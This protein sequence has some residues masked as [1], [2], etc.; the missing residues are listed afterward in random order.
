MWLPLFLRVLSAFTFRNF[1][2]PQ[3]LTHTLIFYIL[4]VLLCT[5]SPSLRL[6]H[7]THVLTK[8]FSIVEVST[9]VATAVDESLSKQHKALFLR[10]QLAAINAELQRLEPGNT[11]LHGTGGVAED[12]DDLDA[13]GRRVDALPAGTEVRRVASTEARRLR[14]IPP[15]NAEHGV[16]RNYVRNSTF[17]PHPRF[18]SNTTLCCFCQ[19]EWLTAL[20]WTLPPPGSDTLMRS[21]FLANAKLQLDADHF[22]LD[23]VKRRLTEYLAVVR[24]RALITQEAEM[25]QAKAHEVELKD[26]IEDQKDKYKDGTSKALVRA[27]DIPSPQILIPSSVSTEA[28]KVTK[29]IKAP[30]L[31]CVSHST[32][33]QMLSWT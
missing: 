27:G 22:G 10:Q 33:V 30:I 7:V 12:E 8:Q 9:K 23:K 6:Q 2:G 16:V 32:F 3:L 18:L 21:D 20:P 14:R 28:R 4:A 26:A 19:L 15:Q 5:E 24:L 25:E 1:T 13:L 31:L 17:S 29:A 11:D